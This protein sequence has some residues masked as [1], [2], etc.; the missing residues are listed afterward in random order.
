MGADTFITRKDSTMIM[1]NR[2]YAI[3]QALPILWYR[4]AFL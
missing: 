4:K 3:A 2:I 1:M